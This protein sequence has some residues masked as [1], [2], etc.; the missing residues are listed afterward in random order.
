MSRLGL[1]VLSLLATQ[2]FALLTAHACSIAPM[3]RDDARPKPGTALPAN[4]PE[5][6]WHG[7]S[8][9]SAQ[10]N[11]RLVAH[12]ANGENMEVAFDTNT[13]DLN[14][15]QLHVRSALV[16]G[17]TLVLSYD[18]VDSSGQEPTPIE[19]S[20]PV[21]EVIELPT[22]LGSLSASVVTGS[23][24][25]ATSTGE[26]ARSV[27]GSYADLAIALDERARPLSDTLRYELRVDGDQPWIFFDDPTAMFTLGMGSSSL[28]YGRDRL[29]VACDDKPYEPWFLPGLRPT[30]GLESGEH[31]VRMVGLMPD[32]SE[33]S[34][35]EITVDLSCP[36]APTQA[37]MESASEPDARAQSPAADGGGCSLSRAQASALDAVPVLLALAALRRRRRTAH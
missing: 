14:F 1:F 28:G 17:S 31:R 22:S 35:D 26:C 21:V 34:S 10:L 5:L 20:W 13:S 29:L 27:F 3:C 18:G 37:V 2:A 8:F 15:V 16:P 36:G 11:P 7:C 24:R 6:A 19:L 23:V 33:L 32:G 12:S 4:L 9:D 30:P 25:A